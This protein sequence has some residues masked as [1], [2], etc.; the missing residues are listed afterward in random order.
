M[1]AAEIS[2]PVVPPDPRLAHPGDQCVQISIAIQIIQEDMRC[3]S[4]GEN[5]L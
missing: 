3:L 4:A 1:V 5:P 2:L